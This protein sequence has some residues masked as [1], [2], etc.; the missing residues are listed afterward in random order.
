MYYS[1]KMYVESINWD[2][3]LSCEISIFVGLL[4][5]GVA[6]LLGVII[7]EV[8]TEYKFIKR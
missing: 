6:L 5:I 3:V 8:L 7:I 2:R 1:H 4:I